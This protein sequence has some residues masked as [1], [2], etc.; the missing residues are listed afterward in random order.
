MLRSV[1]VMLML[2]SLFSLTACGGSGGSSSSAAVS[3]V[4]SGAV[5]KGPV[6]GALVDIYTMTSNGA[7]NTF[8]VTSN[9]PTDVYGNWAATVPAG[10]VGPFIAVSRGG[11]FTDEYTGVAGV[12]APAMRTIWDGT[13]TA[14]PIT[15]LTSAV[16]DAVYSYAVQNNTNASNAFAAVKRNLSTQLGFDPVTT[17]VDNYAYV[18]ALTSVSASSGTSLAGIRAGIAKMAAGLPSNADVTPPIITLPSNIT[19]EATG[20]ATT[21]VAIGVATATDKT[22]GTVTPSNNAPTAYPLGVTRVAWTASD[23]YGNVATAIQRVTIVDTTSPMVTAPAD[24][25]VEATAILTPYANLG[26]ATANDAVNGLIT[27]TNN[28]PITFP[29][30]ITQVTWTASDSYGNTGK[31]VQHVIVSDTTR[32]IVTA[33]TPV[34]FEATGLQTIVPLGTAS[35]VDHAGSPVMATPSQTSFPIGQTTVTWTATDAS[36]NVGTATQ[37]VIVQDTTAPVITLNPLPGTVTL[38][39]NFI[40]P[41]AVAADRVDG[42]VNVVGV[43]NVNTAILGQYTLAYNRTDAAGNVATQLIRTINV[44]NAPDLTAPVVTPPTNITVSAAQGATTVPATQAT[45][46]TFLAA[47]TATDNIAVVGAVT[48]NAPTTLPVGVT[49]VTFTAKDAANNIGTASA[50]VTVNAATP[51]AALTPNGTGAAL[52]GGNGVTG[53]LANSPYTFTQGLSAGQPLY[54]VS[55]VSGSIGNIQAYD[56]TTAGLTR[57]N[58]NWLYTATPAVGTYQCSALTMPSMDLSLN[59]RV[60]TADQCT[61]EITRASVTEV[62]G[63]F[64]AHLIEQATGT[65][66]GTVNDGYFRYLTTP[67]ATSPT[68]GWL[69]TD[70]GATLRAKANQPHTVY[71]TSTT[72]PNIPIGNMTFNISNTAGGLVTGANG[73]INQATVVGSPTPD[74]NWVV[75]HYNFQ[76]GSINGNNFHAMFYNNGVIDGT[77]RDANGSITFTNDSANRYYQKAP[78]AQLTNLTGTYQANGYFFVA[79]PLELSIDAY[80][81]VQYTDP[82]SC[83]VKSLTWDGNG[84]VIDSYNGIQL[85]DPYTGEV[86]HLFENN[87]VFFEFRIGAAKGTNVYRI[88]TTKTVATPSN[89]LL[90]NT[91]LSWCSARKNDTT[92]PVITLPADLYTAFPNTAGMPSSDPYIQGYLNGASALDTLIA[93]SLT[94]T[95]TV[96]NN[97]PTTLPIGVTT[98]TFTATDNQG[99]TATAIGHVHVKFLDAVAPVVSVPA[100]T[101]VAAS[102]AGGLAASDT[103]VQ[104][105]LNG[106]TATDNIDGGIAAAAINVP[107]IL[108]MGAHTITFQA[109]DSSGNVGSGTAVITVR[110]LTAPTITLS[111]NNPQTI[112]QGGTYIEAGA[113]ASDNV[114]VNMSAS[115]MINSTTVNTTVAANYTVTY[116][117][118]DAAGNA[119]TQVTRT[120]QVVAPATFT[121]VATHPFPTTSNLN[122]VV[123][124]NNLFVTVGDAGTILTSS[125]GYS[126]WQPQNSGVADKL[127]AA[128]FDGTTFW[129]VGLDA[130]ASKPMVLSSTNGSQWSKHTLNIGAIGQGFTQVTCGTA[131]LVANNYH[132][133]DGTTW[134]ATLPAK[135]F[136]KV[137]WNAS[138]AQFVGL[139]APNSKYTS[140]D[141]LTWTLKDQWTSMGSDLLWDGRQYVGVGYDT[142][143]FSGFYATSVDLITVSQTFAQVGLTPTNVYFSGLHYIAVDIDGNMSASTNLT[144]WTTQA[145]FG[146]NKTGKAIRA[147]AN[148][149]NAIVAVGD[150]G[151]IFSSP[152]IA[153]LNWTAHK[154]QLTT[155]ELMQAAYDN[156]GGITVVVG[157]AGTIMHSTDLYTWA[158]ATS[159]ITTDLLAV[160]WTG[161]SFVAV[162]SAGVVLTSNNGVNWVAQTS[163]VVGNLTAVVS[164]GS[165]IIATGINPAIG[166]PETIS[167]TNGITWNPAV[168]LPNKPGLVNYTVHFN[169]L[170]NGSQYILNDGYFTYT[171]VNGAAWQQLSTAAGIGQ[172]AAL[173]WDGT[174]LWL[175]A[176]NGGALFTSLDGIT[177]TYNNSSS[178]AVNPN[179]M[180]WDASSQQFILVSAQ[181]IAFG[182]VATGGV[183]T[184][185]DGT[186]WTSRGHTTSS[187][188]HVIKAGTKFLMVGPSG[189]ILITQ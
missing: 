12:T 154:T 147:V 130:A 50:T 86:V 97:A 100:A 74:S 113:S 133:L 159:G 148:N 124:G 13:A 91:G 65:V 142:R 18:A 55:N 20:S 59:G 95:I 82:A 62:E 89:P 102:N 125:D 61:I 122:D 28:A 52:A 137:Y 109:T 2:F 25:Y 56:T 4:I 45:V 135:I 64:A 35:V 115:I 88:D 107:A 21:L 172:V 19:A 17:S 15:P 179:Q 23:T 41:G 3:S 131:G 146:L 38:G 96:T 145:P 6:I 156:V 110:D 123:F 129:A 169:I 42:N 155:N 36:N 158:T 80:G 105:F 54:T 10:A 184:S 101:T 178:G 127:S 103:A 144:T 174:Q 173:T 171:S 51:A 121:P 70:A 83:T 139:V 57:W 40:D 39:S 27:A 157:R 92:P 71:V 164:N 85:S 49:T 112:T 1:A 116:N 181:G 132:S 8:V 141:G 114:D 167:S 138:T 30:G 79:G 37:A 98:V 183:R 66:A 58:I 120:V 149:A 68:A 24:I 106:G 140:P 32:P 87:T 16:A 136:G 73:V 175:S 26:T 119:A 188:N 117:V 84:D 34:T 14:A 72:N 5:S 152:N 33:P 63:R 77:Y 128:C 185:V 46:A 153:T 126:A 22:A 104:S 47:A 143:N 94:D 151:E 9:A 165:T 93:G 44:V 180:I 31:A 76:F 134:T 43:G 81:A 187:L 78:P 48:N 108:T 29:L 60:Y 161:N 170:W 163:N 118:S 53:T 11:T 168:V 67:A 182:G 160:T 150:A 90:G 75:D 162:G 189:M 177:W 7:K 111:G 69:T 166:T 176:V 99:N 186:V